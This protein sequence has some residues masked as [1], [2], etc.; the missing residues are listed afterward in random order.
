M[1]GEELD[2]GPRVDSISE[3]IENELSG[4]EGS[5]FE[6]KKSLVPIEKLDEL[7]LKALSEVWGFSMNKLCTKNRLRSETSTR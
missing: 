6:H 5:K 2:Y 3:F 4:F 1:N 7:F